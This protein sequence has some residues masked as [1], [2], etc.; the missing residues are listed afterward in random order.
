MVICRLRLHL[1]SGCSVQHPKGCGINC[2]LP[3]PRV[4]L[5]NPLAS[6]ARHLGPHGLVLESG[7]AVP[8]HFAALDLALLASRS[9]GD[10]ARTS[11]PPVSA[12]TGWKCSL[13]SLKLCT[14]RDR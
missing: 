3:F 7:M 8:R 12:L 2:H 5:Q 1:S 4:L 11:L 6:A 10:G 13:T 14:E 9:W